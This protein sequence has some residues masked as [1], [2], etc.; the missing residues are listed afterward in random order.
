MTTQEN[1]PDSGKTTTY[2]SMRQHLEWWKEACTLYG[3]AMDKSIN[4]VVRKACDWQREQDAQSAER[5][6]I[7]ESCNNIERIL[8]N[9]IRV[10]IANAIRSGGSHG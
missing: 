5:A 8:C 9:C 4:H 10:E 6:E 2:P 7:P 3:L 1:Q